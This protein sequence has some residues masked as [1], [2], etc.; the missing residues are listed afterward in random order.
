MKS[1]I[2]R[3]GSGLLL[4]G[5]L[6]VPVLGYGALAKAKRAPITS[7]QEQALIQGHKS[8]SKTSYSKRRS[9][10]DRTL[11]CVDAAQSKDDLKTC[12]KQRKETRRALRQEHRAH[13]NQ[14]R[15]QAGLP[16]RDEKPRRRKIRRAPIESISSMLKAQQSPQPGACVKAIGC[17]V[18]GLFA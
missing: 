9:A 12:R 17:F 8:W 1:S 14:V 3:H 5:L 18:V 13:M 11:A 4:L 10:M 2:H 6:A 15:E 16:I 7:Q